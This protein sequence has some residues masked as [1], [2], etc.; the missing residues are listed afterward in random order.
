MAINYASLKIN[1]NTTVFNDPIQELVKYG[2]KNPETFDWRSWNTSWLLYSI[3]TDKDS[4]VQAIE[5]VP[6]LP[7]KLMFQFKELSSGFLEGLNTQ[8]QSMIDRL[9][10]GKPEQGDSQFNI[11]RLTRKLNAY[12]DLMTS[13]SPD[14][15]DEVEKWASRAMQI[16]IAKQ[17]NEAQEK[18]AEASGLI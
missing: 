13:L 2:L 3:E 18:L 12:I 5:E 6:F 8:I 9:S 1:T 7:E 17:A 15:Q 11:I 10:S 4:L 14:K 16:C